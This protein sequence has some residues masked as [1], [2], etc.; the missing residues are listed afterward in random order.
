MKARAIKVLILTNGTLGDLLP[1]LAIAKALQSRGHEITFASS[2]VYAD[3]VA[4]LGCRFIPVN[5]P[6]QQLEI[7]QDPLLWHPQRGFEVIFKHM[8]AQ[9]LHWL[10]TF[11]LQSLALDQPTFI[12]AHPL[13]VPFIDFLRQPDSK[14]TVASVCLAPTGLFSGH[15]CLTLGELNVPSWSPPGF[16]RWL[17]RL[18][19]RLFVHKHIVPALNRERGLLGLVPIQSFFE[20]GLARADLTLALFPAS[21]G[22]PQVDWPTPLVQSGFLLQ[23]QG[24]A[25]L[26][27]A[28]Q[29]F[30]NAGDAPLVFTPGSGHQHAA[31]Y[32]KIAQ[33]VVQKLGRRAIFLTP[34][35]AQIPRDLGENIFWQDFVPLQDLLPHSAMLIHHG[36]IGTTAE[37]MRCAA[38][39]LVIPFAFDQ[40]DNAARIK[41]LG[42][43]DRLNARR[44]DLWFLGEHLLTQK[45][46]HL[47][48]ESIR[49]RCQQIA[50]TAKVA[51]SAFD[52][53]ENLEMF[54]E[55]HQSKSHL[56]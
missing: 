23:A 22:A 17:F 26:P 52:L 5:T 36:G 50:Q 45:I 39:Q 55:S 2:A 38:P 20:Y 24:A 9:W 6:K 51:G 44:L 28:L 49:S 42:I 15:D 35:Q 31:Q 54:C 16:N 40:F 56:A 30:L 10:K 29:Q 18:L 21:F 32:F 13:C 12:I 7:L 46:K 47:S 14:F 41:R 27:E 4:A 34:H 33:R 43:G 1:F 8:Q 25:P 19:L 37:A 53:C 48:T 11:D 3:H